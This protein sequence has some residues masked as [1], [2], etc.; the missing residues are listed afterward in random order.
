MHMKKNTQLDLFLKCIV[1][2]WATVLYGLHTLAGTETGTG[3][4]N[5]W[6]V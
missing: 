1:C 4:G 5:K 3:T 6:V 2:Y